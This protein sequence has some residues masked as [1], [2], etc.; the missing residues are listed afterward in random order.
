ML[1]F[2]GLC[3]DRFHPAIIAEPKRIHADTG[4]KVDVGFAVRTGAD[5]P[6]AADRLQ[7]EPR[8]AVR[9]ILLVQLLES[10][11][12]FPSFYFRLRRLYFSFA[13]TYASSIYGSSSRKVCSPGLSTAIQPIHA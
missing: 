11:S 1:Q 2:S 10:H 8:V 3:A 13:K 5:G 6:L 7:V 4:R 12:D 9:N